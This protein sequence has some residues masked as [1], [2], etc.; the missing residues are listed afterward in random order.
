LLDRILGEV[1]G[2]Q[3]LG[4]IRHLWREGVAEDRRCGCGE[5]FR[6]CPYWTAVMQRGFS[7]VGADAPHVLA[8]QHRVD[9]W[10]RIPVLASRPPGPELREYADLLANLYRAAAAESG[11]RVLVDSSK[12]VSHG[13][14]LR[15]VALL[16]PDIDVRVVHLLRDPRA[17]AF[18]WL[19][20]KDNPGSGRPMDRWPAWRTAV[21]WDVINAGVA[22]LR[23]LNTPYL[24]VDYEQLTDVPRSTVQRILAFAGEPA[25]AV[26][27][28]T[29]GTVE[30]H[31]SHTA[32]GNPDRFRSG[33]TT[34]VGDAEWRSQMRHRDR[35]VVSAL[36][37][38]SVRAA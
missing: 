38:R 28:E 2:V 7:D 6:E 25:A 26:P 4:E 12:D 32:A 18:S 20:H 33:P 5:P 23:R 19:R 16:H 21:E 1:P 15:R 17:V 31:P 14:V 29:D 37:G 11:A 13:Y 35:L 34:V 22:G 3:S 36:T 27:V 9:Q 30:L 24:R 8:L 10:W